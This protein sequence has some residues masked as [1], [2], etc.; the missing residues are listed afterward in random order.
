MLSSFECSVTVTAATQ[1]SIGV[2]EA[3]KKIENHAAAVALYFRHDNLGR[4]P[5]TL[6]VTPAI[7][8][9]VDNHAWSIEE[10]I[11]LLG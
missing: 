6:S 1:N 7:D 2:R 9:G 5:Q 11:G 8:A 10:V 3:S 4:V